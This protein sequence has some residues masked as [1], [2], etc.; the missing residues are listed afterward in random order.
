MREIESSPKA[1]ALMESTRSVGYSFESAVADIVDNS[2]GASAKR[3][4][5]ESL[6]SDNP[7]VAILDDG[8]GL[9]IE[10]LQEAMRYGSNPNNLRTGND[11]GRFGL[12]MKTASLSQCRKLTVISLEEGIIASCRWDLDRVIETNE[13]TLQVLE[14]EEVMHLPLF[15]KLLEQ[16]KGTIVLWECL[17]RVLDKS[18]D[19]SKTIKDEIESCKNHLSMTFHRFMDNEAASNRLSILVNNMKLEPFDPFLSTHPGTK[20]MEEQIIETEN[21]K[22]IVKPFIIPSESKLGPDDIRRIGG[23]DPKMQGFYIY[24]NKRLIISGTWFKLTKTLELR[25]LVRVRVDIPNTLDFM[26]DIDVKK[27]NATIPVQFREQFIKILSKV[28]VSG[29]KR[30]K[31]R[32]R[33]ENEG[34]KTFVWSKIV[35]REK[36]TY[37]INREHPVIKEM[38]NELGDK[39]S[40]QFED[41]L[42]FIEESI[43]FN[44]IYS[45]IAGGEQPVT[46]TPDIDS[47]LSTAMRLVL[48]GSCSLEEIKNMEPFSKHQ[49]IIEKVSEV[50]R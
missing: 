45:T 41:I 40:K 49:S 27:S 15:N 12:G 42:S 18:T 14:E 17:D 7:Y 19:S 39:S 50:V 28:V 29:E 9:D 16:G 24:R 23:L 46:D 31:Y 36:T 21:G 2:I 32:G 10:S 30:I 6:P 34:G 20:M 4:I 1:A 26:W 43:P 11:L 25:K 38:C 3:I 47:M 37:L 33:K 35:N 48:S 5:I 22:I 44:D 8:D 13:W